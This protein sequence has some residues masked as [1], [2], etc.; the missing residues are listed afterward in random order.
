MKVLLHLL[1]SLLAAT[2][3]AWPLQG[4]AADDA[5]PQRPIRL[6]VPFA[7]GG[8]NDLLARMVADRLSHEL[9]KPVVVDNRTGAGGAIGT[10]S[11]AKATPDGYTMLLGNSATHAINLFLYAHLP[12][13]PVKDF[14]PISQAVNLNFALVTS[15]SL[16]VKDFRDFMELAKRKPGTL[17]FASAGVGTVTQLGVEVLKQMTGATFDHI[18]YR[19]AGPALIDLMGGQVNFMFIDLSTVLP[20]LKGGKLRALAVGSAQ[21]SPLLPG[22][23]TI[24]ESG[25]PGFN[26]TSWQGFFFPAGTPKDIV[27]KAQLAIQ[28]VL[29]TPEV[30]AEL[31]KAGYDPV[32]SDS[33]HFAAFI[34]AEIAKWSAAAKSAGVKPE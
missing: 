21:R 17:T 10:A 22:V 24:A 16:P 27:T 34:H 25:V 13:D 8:G 9:G 28:K 1:G 23:P 11:V 7:A 5:W 20:Q 31:I 4:V 6:V 33:E 19:G 26:V 30:K 14:V 15:T 32:G 3:M 12:Y 29:A 2:L 18:P